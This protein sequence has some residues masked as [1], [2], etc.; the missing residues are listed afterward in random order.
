MYRHEI[1]WSAVTAGLEALQVAHSRHANRMDIAAN[2]IAG[3]VGRYVEDD[4]E[5]IALVEDALEV[6]FPDESQ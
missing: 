4:D 6:I 3:V 2:A 1:L 5:G